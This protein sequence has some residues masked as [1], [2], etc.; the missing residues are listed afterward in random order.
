MISAERESSNSILICFNAIAAADRSCMPFG[1]SLAD[2]RNLVDAV[3]GGPDFTDSTADTLK[4]KLVTLDLHLQCL[5][6]PIH[7][8]HTDIDPGSPPLTQQLH[9]Q[10][11]GHWAG[12]V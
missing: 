12:A 7:P 2:D 9:G 6:L 1:V 5:G 3:N 4:I 8:Y 11:L 10:I